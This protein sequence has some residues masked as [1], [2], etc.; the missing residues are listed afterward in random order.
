MQQ[1][2]KTP[3]FNMKAVV[4]ETGI[5]PDTLRAWERRYDL[6]RP[7]RTEGGHRIYS[8]RD[9]DTLKWLMARQGEGLSISNAVELFK[10]LEREGQDPVVA[11]GLGRSD[12]PSPVGTQFGG[13]TIREMREAWVTACVAFDESA[14]EKILSEAFAM[15]TPELVCVE[16]LQKGMAMIGQ[17]WY[18]GTTTVQQEHFASALAMRRLEALLTG[19]PLAIRPGRVLIGCPP[20]EQ[21]TFGPMILAFLL[22]RRGWD[23]VYLGANVPVEQ[24]ESTLD[25]VRPKLT[26]FLAQQLVSAATLFEVAAY[27]AGKNAQMAYGGRIFVNAPAL[28]RR[29]EG[30]YLGDTLTGAIPIVE[31][32]LTRREPAPLA[33]PAPEEYEIAF[34]YLEQRKPALQSAV[35]ASLIAQGKTPAQFTEAGA[36]LTGYV[37]AALRLGDM[38]LIAAELEWLSGLLEDRQ[39][40]LAQLAAYLEAYYLALVATLDDRGRPITDWFE[41]WVNWV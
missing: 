40:D 4:S 19:M 27:A 29:I 5:R 15:F 32:L 25:A 24:L 12:E 2:K 30:H 8:Q 26:I 38:N 9:V 33:E 21:H 6:P 13:G 31:R 18:E 16:V 36:Y 3:T 17:G 11:S 37:S 7:E 20:H 10:R 35:A 39:Q 23:V 22:R 34:H 14:A 1:T 28:Q 41:A